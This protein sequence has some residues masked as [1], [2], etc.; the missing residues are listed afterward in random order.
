VAAGISIPLSPLAGTLG[1]SA[2]P[3]VFALALIG[4]VAAYLTVV[5]LGKSLFFSPPHP[6]E[7]TSRLRGRI[8]R[9]QRRAARFSTGTTNPRR[10]ANP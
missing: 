3:P 4:L 1:F 6:S 5:E 2:P 7:A 9:V 10:V 8:H